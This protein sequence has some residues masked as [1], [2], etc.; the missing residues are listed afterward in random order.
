MLADLLTYDALRERYPNLALPARRKLEELVR[1]E[2]LP[3][4]RLT[5]R[6]AMLYSPAEIEAWL[7]ERAEA[8][9]A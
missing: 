8:A 9:H 1:L 7:T 5:P 2:G 6:G 3:G 4:R